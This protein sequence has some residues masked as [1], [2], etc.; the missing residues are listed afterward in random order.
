LYNFVTDPPEAMLKSLFLYFCLLFSTILCAQLPQTS[1]GQSSK[2]DSLVLKYEEEVRHSKELL[3]KLSKANDIEREER[4]IAIANR[5]AELLD[6]LKTLKNQYLD[7]SDLLIN[8]I[9]QIQ[10]LSAFTAWGE[11]R[12]SYLQLVNPANYGDFQEALKEVYADLDAQRKQSMGTVVADMISNVTNFVAQPLSIPNAIVSLAGQYKVRK[13][14]T[15]AARLKMETAMNFIDA[16]YQELKKL[17]DDDESLNVQLDEFRNKLI[18]YFSRYYESFNQ[19]D[20]SYENLGNVRTSKNEIRRLFQ[21][22]VEAYFNSLSDKIDKETGGLDMLNSRE[23]EFARQVSIKQM[24]ESLKFTREYVIQYGQLR[25]KVK[26]RV[27]IFK[28]L[29]KS[30]NRTKNLRYN[31][32]QVIKQTSQVILKFDE[33]AYQLQNSAIESLQQA[34]VFR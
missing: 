34:V 24:Q 30:Y 32:D 11:A 23:R 2:V 19:G 31:A 5:K 22:R 27:V 25:E 12:S 8:I 15:E 17:D 21:E 13:E 3:E 7:G 29:A 14:K 20:I 1:P 16:K 33:G 6:K 4:R 26:N 10:D 18:A 9:S 28:N